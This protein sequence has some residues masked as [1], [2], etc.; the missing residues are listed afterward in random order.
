M[1]DVELAYMAEHR[2]TSSRRDTR[3]EVA[4]WV[5]SVRRPHEAWLGVR[6]NAQ[7]K[8][9]RGAARVVQQKNIWD[10]IE[11]SKYI[12]ELE[13]DW[14]GEGGQTYSEET[15]KRATGLLSR[16][17]TQMWQVFGRL[18]DAPKILPGPDGSI[19]IH[20]KS[21]NSEMLVNLPADPSEL[22]SFYGDD[23]GS[24]RIKGSFD[25]DILNLGLLSWFIR[26]L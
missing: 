6:Q 19:D 21:A 17:A 5:P 10:A 18:M 2:A 25:P 15:W 20:W 4:D 14:D 26:D 9:A 11:S 8:G 16:Y 3:R 13:N 1:A 23:Y 12:L 24:A 7:K 22:A